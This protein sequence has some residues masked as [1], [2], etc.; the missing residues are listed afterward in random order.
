MATI[1]C[2]SVPNVKIKLHIET[3]TIPFVS[4]LYKS[5]QFC[6]QDDDSDIFSTPASTQRQPYKKAVTK[7]EDLF[8]DDTDIFADLPTSKP[9]KTSKKTAASSIFS[10]DV[11]QL[12][13]TFA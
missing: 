2:Y 8:K 9:K 6:F 12:I 11:G 5:S 3:S 4:V 1:F 10:D 13:V 7:D